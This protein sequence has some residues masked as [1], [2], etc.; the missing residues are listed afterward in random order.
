MDKLK[1]ESTINECLEFTEEI[2]ESYPK[3]KK[4]EKNVLEILHCHTIILSVTA[5]MALREAD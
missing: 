4:F 1:I 3:G 2:A 5:K